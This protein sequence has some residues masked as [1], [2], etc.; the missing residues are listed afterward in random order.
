MAQAFFPPG[1]G[2]TD[3]RDRDGHVTLSRGGDHHPNA[4]P[5]QGGRQDAHRQVLPR[6]LHGCVRPGSRARGSLSLQLAHICP[7]PTRRAAVGTRQC[8]HG[9]ESGMRT[10]GDYRARS[11]VLRS[12]S[13]ERRVHPG[14]TS[15]GEGR[16]SLLDALQICTHS[17]FSSYPKKN[18]TPPNRRRVHRQDRRALP[19]HL[20]PE[21]PLRG[22]PDHCAGGTG[23]RHVC[24]GPEKRNP[25]TSHGSRG[26]AFWEYKRRETARRDENRSVYR[27]TRV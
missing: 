3:A 13:R 7:V 20:R 22:A 10:T 27:R 24:T 26:N 15:S 21:G 14:V 1:G 16:A 9:R 5:R 4:A 12:E 8:E 19:P 23:A 6:R 18:T 17:N 11:S 2:G 25:D